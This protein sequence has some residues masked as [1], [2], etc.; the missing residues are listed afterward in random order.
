MSRIHNA[1]VAVRAYDAERLTGD[2]LE[3]LIQ[4]MITDAL[5]YATRE[6]SNDTDG[7]IRRALANYEAELQ[8]PQCDYCGRWQD[9][10]LELEWNGETG[11][12]VDCERK[13]GDQ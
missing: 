6:C 4:D 13:A 2:D 11:Q 7:I 5:H 1:A 8:E 12:H 10:S 9:E 3:T